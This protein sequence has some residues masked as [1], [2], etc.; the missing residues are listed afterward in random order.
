M[1]NKIILLVS[2]FAVV[3]SLVSCLKDDVGEYW[4]DD[5]AGKMYATV[6]VPALQ[7]LALKPVAGDVKYEF[8]VNIA[9][10]ALPT[11]DITLTLKIDPAA[12]TEYNTNAGKSYKPY[13]NIEILTKSIL[14]AKGTRNATAQIKVWGAEALNACD[15]YIAG[16][17]IESATTAS[18][19]TITIAGNMK[20]NLTALPISNPYAGDYHLVGYRIHPAYVDPLTVD[21]TTAASTVDCKTIRKPQMGDYPYNCDITITAETMTVNGATVNK[22]IV[23]SPDV[24]PANFG[25]YDTYTGSA[26]TPPTPPSTDVNYYNPATKTFVLNYFYLSAGVPR[27]IYEVLTR[28]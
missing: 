4:K 15:N 1:K 6:A 8:L 24:A 27:K 18:G 9:T 13:P 19:G 2:F 23:S 7:Q 20:S 12:V 26:A 25:M 16:V 22:V 17:S 10:D 5:L 14:I 28:L 21:K 3:F 11:E